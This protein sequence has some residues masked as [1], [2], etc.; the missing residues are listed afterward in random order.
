[1]SAAKIIKQIMVE[2]GTTVRE[3]AGKLGCTPRSLSNRLYR[4]TF[5][6]SDYI[7]IVSTL[8]CTVQ[9]VTDTGKVFQ[10][11]NEPD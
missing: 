11:E 9:T 7:K 5:T 1:M 3:L 4:D 6:Y 10:N 8:G 2:T